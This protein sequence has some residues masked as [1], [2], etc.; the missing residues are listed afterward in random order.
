MARKHFMGSPTAAERLAREQA[1]EA[2][3]APRLSAQQ[4]E[5]RDIPI[6]RLRPNP[7]QARRTFADLEELAEAIKAQGFITRL[8]VRPDPTEPGAFQLVFGERRLRAARLAG[9]TVL[10]CEIAQHSDEELIEIGLAENIQRQDLHPLEEAH[11]FQLFLH[12]RGYSIRRLAERIG[13]DKSYIEDRLALLRV[14]DDVQ[15]MVIHRPDSLRAAREIAKLPTSEARQPLIEGVAGGQLNT[16]Q[17][18]TIVR[19]LV[20]ERLVD[21]DQLEVATQH[22]A[23]SAPVRGVPPDHR[24]LRQRLHA[25]VHAIRTIAVRWRILQAQLPP[26]EQETL[27]QIAQEMADLF[28]QL[29]PPPP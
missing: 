16:T 8:R 29:H 20:A 15:E 6:D 9:L 2:L 11:A 21:Q 24:P 22:S 3:F 26:D 7:F 10:P 4:T 18:R 5:L 1:V 14:P 17:V 28:D 19:Q 23:P 27:A 25:D 12:E 13:K